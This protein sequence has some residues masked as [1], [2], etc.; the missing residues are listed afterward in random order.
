MCEE[1]TLTADKRSELAKRLAD[2]ADMLAKSAQLR[3]GHQRGEGAGLP[4]LT[5]N[6]R[7]WR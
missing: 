7:I 3:Y 1:D 5:P 2:N 4:G 6:G